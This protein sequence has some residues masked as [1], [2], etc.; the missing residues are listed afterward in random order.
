MKVTEQK[1]YLFKLKL[2]TYENSFTNPHI[3]QLYKNVKS[4]Y[5]ISKYFTMYT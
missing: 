5:I 4:V 2:I 3:L 1:Y